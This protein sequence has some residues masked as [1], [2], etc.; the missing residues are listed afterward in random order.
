MAPLHFAAKSDAFLSLDC[1]RVEGVGARG[2]EGIQFCHLAT[3]V[4]GL[5]RN[6]NTRR[7]QGATNL[8]GSFEETSEAAATDGATVEGQ[9]YFFREILR[10]GANAATNIRNT[11][12]TVTGLKQSQ[13]GQNRLGNSP[14]VE[15][16]GL[17]EDLL[18]VPASIAGAVNLPAVNINN[19]FNGI[20]VGGQRRNPNL[21][22][23]AKDEQET[24]EDE[25]SKDAST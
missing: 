10:H 18:N 6:P 24:P 1:A 15:G 17:I 8:R 9:G 13:E 4:A 23:G 3:M 22:Q 2:K 11:F 20:N 21:G 19:Q 7:Q 14:T 25:Q 5:K 12:K 16:Q